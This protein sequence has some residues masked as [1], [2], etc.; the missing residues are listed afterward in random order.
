ML[1]T[2]PLAPTP[3]IASAAMQNPHA[4]KPGTSAARNPELDL[5]IADIALLAR[6]DTAAL[7]RLYDRYS[8]TTFAAAYQLLQDAAAAEDAVQDAYMRAWRNAASF[9]RHRGSVRS[10][11]V[12]IA[13][14]AAI[15][16]L[17]SRAVAQRFQ[18]TLIRLEHPASS[19]DP[20]AVCL[21]TAE[22]DRLHRALGALPNEQRLAIELAFF[23]GLTHMEIATRTGAPLGT[24]KGRVRLGLRRLRDTLG[25]SG[26]P[27]SRPESHSEIIGPVHHVG[28]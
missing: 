24:V 2:R 8:R 16:Q 1:T 20:A 17:R 27:T 18:S 6:G 14:H 10:W 7:G 4:G 15:D 11:L 19:D 21:L 26:A 5:D 23:S 22:V 13:R 3:P 28:Q 25:D 9:Q 12:S